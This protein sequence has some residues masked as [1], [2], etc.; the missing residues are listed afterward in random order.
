MRIIHVASG[1]EWRGGQ[2]QVW[3]LARTLQER[4]QGAPGGPGTRPDQ[5]VVTG[6][7]TELER[8]LRASGVPVRAATWRSGADPRALWAT[9]DAARRGPCLLHAH[10]GHAVTLAGLAAILCRR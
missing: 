9:I 1:R 10:D 5:V 3:L 8:R 2:N 4:G 6:A 7:G